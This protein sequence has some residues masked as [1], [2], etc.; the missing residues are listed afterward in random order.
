MVKKLITAVGCVALVAFALSASAAASGHRAN[1]SAGHT[2]QGRRIRV[3]IYGQKIELKHFTV[4]LRC[5]GAS[6]IDI[7]SGFLPS[8]LRNRDRIHDHQ[9]GSTDDVYIRGRLGNHHLHGAIRV[10]DRLGRRRCDSHWVRFSVR[11]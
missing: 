9:V 10:R 2:A 1:V 7:E 4:G 11:R 6:L 8:R 3:A 5:H